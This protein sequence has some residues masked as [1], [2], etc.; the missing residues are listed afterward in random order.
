MKAFNSTG[1]HVSCSWLQYQFQFPW[2][3]RRQDP[4][5]QWSWRIE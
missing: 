4:F 3:L 2:R 1:S 5:I